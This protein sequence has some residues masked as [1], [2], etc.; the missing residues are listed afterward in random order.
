MVS[1]Q[2]KAS[3]SMDLACNQTIDDMVG[4]QSTRPLFAVNQSK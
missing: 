1:M 3:M 2:E 4:S